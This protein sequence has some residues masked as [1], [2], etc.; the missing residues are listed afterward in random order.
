[1]LKGWASELVDCLGRVDSIVAAST[2]YVSMMTVEREGWSTAVADEGVADAEADAKVF[3]FECL[4]G[5][6]LSSMQ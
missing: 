1:M 6:E 5:A 4:C 2:G 3:E